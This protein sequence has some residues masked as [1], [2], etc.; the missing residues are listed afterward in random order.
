MFLF[1]EEKL[2]PPGII[3]GEKTRHRN[4]VAAETNTARNELAAAPFLYPREAPARR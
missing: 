1:N 2:A 3:G 4:T